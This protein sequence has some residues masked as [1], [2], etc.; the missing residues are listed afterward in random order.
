MILADEVVARLRDYL[1]G[2][3]TLD[4]FEDWLVVKSW[5]MHRDSPPDAQEAVGAVELALAE[6]SSGHLSDEQLRDRLAIVAG[7][8]F[9]ER[10]GSG[11]GATPAT[12]TLPPEGSAARFLAD[13]ARRSRITLRDLLALG[14]KALPCD[15]DDEGCMGVADD[16]RA[17]E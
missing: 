1:A 6:H 15:C 12:A 10:R 11:E 2:R 9:T 8:E 16:V 7:G 14:A 13:Y 5:N 17:E 4:E 3:Q